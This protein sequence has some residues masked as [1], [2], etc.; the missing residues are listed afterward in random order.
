[1]PR[2]MPIT[3]A[4]AINEAFDVCLK[5]D[6][7]VFIIGLGVPDP[8]G[9]FGTTV[10]LSKKYGKKR[11]MDMPISENALTGVCIGAA[12]NGMRP[13]LTHQRIDFSL[14]G[15]E[16]VI[17]NAAKWYY[18]FGGKQG[19]PLVIKMT[20]GMGWGQGAQHSQNLQALYAHIPGLKVVMPSTPY[21]AK[22]LMIAAIEDNNPVI[23]ID[24]RWLHGMIDDVPEGYYHLPIGKARILKRGGDITIVATS[25]MAVESLRAAELLEKIHVRAEVVDVRSI[26]PLDGKTIAQSLK[27][28]RRLLVADLGNRSFGVAA[29]IIAAVAEDNKIKLLTNPQRIT[30]PDLPTPSTPALAEHYYPRYIDIARKATEIVGGNLRGLENLIIEEEA[31]RIVPLDVPDMSFKGPF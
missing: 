10:G 13:V 11:I 3:Y 28:T 29:E 2:K 1:M 17:N 19:V 5:K 25:Y 14:L 8:K 7:T 12:I 9:I 15:V 30:S 6:K 16:Q 31:S 22:G 4:E 21:D 20:I 26:R 27:K 23:Y 24:H 18:M